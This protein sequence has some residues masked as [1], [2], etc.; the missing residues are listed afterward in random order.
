[1]KATTISI[2]VLL[3]ITVNCTNADTQW[4]SF[5]SPTPA[6]VEFDLIE[7]SKS[8][9]V[10][11]VIIPGMYVTD[12]T[13]D[14][15]EYDR[16]RVPGGLMT[17]E[18]G[19]PE[20]PNFVVQLCIPQCS[21]IQIST[22]PQNTLYLSDYLAYPVP[23]LVLIEEPYISYWD[24]DFYRDDD[25]YAIPG[26]YPGD[27]A[28]VSDVEYFR[29][30]PSIAVK[31]RPILSDPV[32]QQL[33]VYQTL[34]VTVSFIGGVGNVVEELPGFEDVGQIMFLNRGEVV[35]TWYEFEEGDW[36][37]L[38]GDEEP[39]N[40]NAHYLVIVADPFHD[41]TPSKEKLEEWAAHR[42]AMN[43]LKVR[44][45]KH[46]DIEI[47]HEHD[48]AR[49]WTYINNI[50]QSE[51]GADRLRYLLI[52][53]DAYFDQEIQLSDDPDDIQGQE[54]PLLPMIAT[55]DRDCDWRQFGEGGRRWCLKN[56][57]YYFSRLHG[58]DPTAA[59]NW[60]CQIAFGRLSVGTHIELDMVIDK[61]ID[62]E[63]TD[64]VNYRNNMFY[65]AGQHIGQRWYDVY[66]DPH[67]V[68]MSD[69]V[70]DEF[71]TTYLYPYEEVYNFNGSFDETIQVGDDFTFPEG[72][73]I[74]V[75]ARREI[76]DQLET[77]GERDGCLIMYYAGHGSR[78]NRLGFDFLIPNEEGF[79]EVENGHQLP[80]ILLSSCRNGEFDFDEEE[81]GFCKWDGLAEILTIKNNHGGIGVLAA[82]RL[83][84]PWQTVY[85]CTMS[86]VLRRY[87]PNQDG[88]VV[89]KFIL[90]TFRHSLHRNFETPD[91]GSR[92]DFRGS[93]TF[94]GEPGVNMN[95][96][97]SNI[98]SDIDE[99]ETWS[100]KV[101]ITED[102]YVLDDATLTIE[103][104]TE[105]IFKGGDWDLIIYGRLVADGQSDGNHILFRSFFNDKTGCVYLSSSDGNGEGNVVEYC[106]FAGMNKGLYINNSVVSCQN[107]RAHDCFVGIDIY[108]C[109]GFTISDCQCFGNNYGIFVSH[110]NS[111][112]EINRAECHNNT[113]SGIEVILGSSIVLLNDC[114]T[115]HNGLY[116]VLNSSGAWIDLD[117]TKMDYNGIA[118]KASFDA[119][120][121][122]VSH[123]ALRYSYPGPEF[124]L[125]NAIIYLCYGHNDIIPFDPEHEIIACDMTFPFPGHNLN[126]NYLGPPGFLD[127][128]RFEPDDDGWV[129][130]DVD[131]E[132]NVVDG[133]DDGDEAYEALLAAA[134]LAREGNYREGY[135]TF[136]RVIE[137]YPR[138]NHSL[139]ALNGLFY[140]AR[141]ADRFDIGIRRYCLELAENSP[142]RLMR[143]RAARFATRAYVTLGMYEEAIREY[144]NCLRNIENRADSI[145]TAIE[146]AHAF[147]LL[148][149]D[150]RNRQQSFDEMEHIPFTDLI[151]SNHRQ[152]TAKLHQLSMLLDE[153]SHNSTNPAIPKEFYLAQNY[154]NPFN[155]STCI[156]Y[157]LC[158][159]TN[160]KIMI[161]DVSGRLVTTLVND[162]QKAGYYSAMW[163]GNSSSDRSVSS[164]IYFYRMETDTFVKSRKMI[165][166]K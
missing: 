94:I 81:D 161:Y 33:T 30:Q 71:W 39:Q 145:Y 46:S 1:M 108:N 156:K 147:F 88:M 144:E 95:W 58:D 19:H 155:S 51:E 119:W 42:A 23:D 111:N 112:G 79:P 59:M 3:T 92:Y 125:C 28:L 77:E 106:E 16:M 45:V 57:D 4:V 83:I 160:V 100:G 87:Y 104:G 60:G 96:N 164:G 47:E 13:E 129:F 105:I 74:N 70:P 130:N 101:Y 159:D 32:T 41:Y 143:P 2:V 110:E 122:L 24:E 99:D 146:L 54:F 140:C 102:V 48:W 68:D 115:N 66:I 17:D 44:M 52:V 107:N 84:T 141:P 137:E 27:V 103:P 131:D 128:D 64:N 138:S 114:K 82:P 126:G 61:I 31:I 6:E 38:D 36:D 69:L 85:G 10:F 8:Q 121:W 76:L 152:Y 63:T 134:T 73:P 35:E 163:T 136:L 78:N 11:D 55:A 15:V 158:E 80:L 157:G 148:R 12:Y 165:I 133:S 75:E 151:V 9:V 26:N 86:D 25:A 14:Y 72:Y 142:N 109:D 117:S 65:T 162:Q 150:E 93:Y 34:R 154:P 18:L 90:G 97:T 29:E 91:G 139:N 5:S 43:G 120:P 116:G 50:Y 20:V 166:L 124:E 7:S 113:I 98:S 21:D 135:N 37:W 127:T 89:G 40:V 149:G 153:D 132:P 118:L 56:N 49:L 67:F 62:Y 53:G 22:S 123:N